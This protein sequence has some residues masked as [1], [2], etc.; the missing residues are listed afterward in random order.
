MFE[1]SYGCVCP[2]SR[3]HQFSVLAIKATQLVANSSNPLQTLLELSQ[4]FPKYASDLSH[5]VILNESVVEEVQENNVKAQGG[6]SMMWLN[7]VTVEEKDINPQ[8]LLRLLRKERHIMRSLASLG[9]SPRQ[10]IDLLTHKAIY[11]AQQDSAGAL[12]GIFDASDRPEGGDVIVWWND[13]TQDSRY[14][15]WNPSLTGVSIERIFA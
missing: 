6:A 8:G 5:R 9:L 13:L 4:N 7:G 14:A 3:A 1:V 12:D 11:G 10:S 2:S 15:R